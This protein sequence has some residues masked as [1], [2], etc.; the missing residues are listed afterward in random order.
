MRGWDVS[1]PFG[2]TIIGAMDTLERQGHII[3]NMKNRK[4]IGE[5]N[6]ALSAHIDY[7]AFLLVPAVKRSGKLLIE[8][9]RAE[10][11]GIRSYN[12]KYLGMTYYLESMFKELITID[13]LIKQLVKEVMEY[14]GVLNQYQAIDE[15]SRIKKQQKD[16]LKLI[17]EVLERKSISSKQW[18]VFVNNL[19]NFTTH[20]GAL[21]IN[22]IEAE[23]IHFYKKHWDRRFKVS[24]ETVI[25]KLNK[26]MK[27]KKALGEGLSDV[28][29]WKTKMNIQ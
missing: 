12:N 5:I 7:Y 14:T 10:P 17:L 18:F 19:R 21:T 1:D 2:L 27:I 11:S 24:I 25:K 28:N 9:A 3:H 26:F 16:V 22:Y 15:D 20:E 4:R 13:E 8:D 23:N 6:W 29:F